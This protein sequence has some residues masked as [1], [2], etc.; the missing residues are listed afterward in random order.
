MKP[1]AGTIVERAKAEGV[2][3][4]EFG[5]RRVRAVTHLNVSR[6]DCSQAGDILARILEQK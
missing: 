5:P 1:D 4:N 6:E 3:L 2:L